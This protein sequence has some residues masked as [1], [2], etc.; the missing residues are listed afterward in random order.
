MNTASLSWPRGVSFALIVNIPARYPDATFA[1]YVPHAQL[2][3]TNG[4][5]IAELQA[6]WLDAGT[7]RQLRITCADTSAWP[8][9][10][11]IFDVR[12]VSGATAAGSYAAYL[13]VM[14]NATEV[15]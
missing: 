3:R 11:H 12:I 7:T 2:R 1:G 15:V 6:A 14:Q 10:T 4:A 8:V 5:L 9:G 13:S